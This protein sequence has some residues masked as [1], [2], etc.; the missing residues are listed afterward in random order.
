M[1][2]KRVWCIMRF[3]S[4]S[5]LSR[6]LLFFA[7]FYFCSSSSFLI[8]VVV[9]AIASQSM[10]S[11]HCR[12]CFLKVNFK[13]S[14]YIYICLM[15]ILF[16][17]YINNNKSLISNFKSKLMM[18]SHIDELHPY[19]HTHTHT[20]TGIQANTHNWWGFSLSSC[21]SRRLR[22]RNRHRLCCCCC[23]CCFFF[24]NLI[25]ICFYAK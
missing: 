8:A 25:S 7:Y 17:E 22:R 19:T 4:S 14:I 15:Q 18:V 10:C 5:F 1:K 20:H 11:S 9:V 6:S 13:K 3:S 21:S 23:R 12:C 24:S 2:S 16:V